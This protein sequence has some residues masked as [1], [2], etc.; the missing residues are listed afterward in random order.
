M[1]FELIKTIDRG[2]QLDVLG[3][4]EAQALPGVQEDFIL[5][6]GSLLLVYIGG[7]VVEQVGEIREISILDQFYGSVV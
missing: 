5:A 3:Q 6:E 4:E 7:K 2:V 1:L